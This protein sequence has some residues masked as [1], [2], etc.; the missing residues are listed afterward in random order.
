MKRLFYGLTLMGTI[1]AQ[2]QSSGDDWKLR[3]NFRL[4]SDLHWSTT[5]NQPNTF[6]ARFHGNTYLEGSLSNK[7]LRLDLGL[8]EMGKPLPGFD[9]NQGRGVSHLALSGHYRGF[10]L[11]LGDYYTQFGSG[12]LLRAYRDENLGIDNAFRGIYTGYSHE[13]WGSAKLLVGQPRKYFDR[14]LIPP[15]DEG[16]HFF[17]NRNRGWVYGADYE[18]ELAG[19]LGLSKTIDRRISL[20]ASYVVKSE[21]Q[22]PLTRFLKLKDKSDTYQIIQPSSVQGW[23]FRGHYTSGAWE[24]MLEHAQKGQDPAEGNGYTFGHGTATMLTSTYTKGQMSLLVGVRRSENFDFRASRSESGTA[25]RINHLLPFTQQQTFSLAALY[26]YA[27]QPMGEW[28]FQTEWRYKF[29][30]KTTLGGRYGS[31][32]RL[33]VSYVRGLEKSDELRRAGNTMYGEDTPLSA[34]FGLGELYFYDANVEYSRKVSKNYSF[35]LTY[36]HQAYNQEVIEGHSEKDKVLYS[37]IGVYEGRHR[38]SSKLY[39]RTELQYRYSQEGDRD[40]LYAMGELSLL[41][42]WVLSV[43]DLWNIG[44][45]KEHYYLLSATSTFG[46]HRIQLSWGKTRAG[47][48][49]SGGVCRVVP[50]TE[51][52]NLSYVVTL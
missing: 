44:G 17:L 10:E 41:P 16:R 23:S 32:L 38:L 33:G 50:K 28:A 40:W 8:E 6:S 49:C 51:G 21:E 48:N 22:Q 2:A 18:V 45:S 43:S 26:P 5:P 25:L 11:R 19:L 7:Y 35:S 3:S 37:H 52:F 36:L 34:Y 24:V 39:L 9:D 15:F 27:T 31:S 29:K 4:R 30:K 20:G 13:R 1:C 42:G 12:M 46:A 47:V 14:D